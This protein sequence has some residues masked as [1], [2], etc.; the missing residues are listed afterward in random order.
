MISKSLNVKC[1]SAHCTSKMCLFWLQ[2]LH[3]VYILVL[4]QKGLGRCRCCIIS[5]LGIDIS[6]AL[7]SHSQ[8]LLWSTLALFLPHL[9]RFAQWIMWTHWS[10]D[11]EPLF[12]NAGALL[13]EGLPYACFAP[14]HARGYYLTACHYTLPLTAIAFYSKTQRNIHKRAYA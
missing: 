12:G 9:D 2:I 10:A 5:D 6:T 14:V 13:E 8:S 3:Y 7:S 4:I 11:W 1:G